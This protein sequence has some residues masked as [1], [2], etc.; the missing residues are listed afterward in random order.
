MREL[1]LKLVSDHEGRDATL[2]PEMLRDA[3]ERLA[4]RL[5]TASRNA[6]SDATRLGRLLDEE[7]T[8]I[9]RRIAAFILLLLVGAS[10]LLTLF[11]LRMTRTITAS[12]TTLRK[13]TE[14]VGAGNLGHRMGMATEDEIGELSSSFDRMT[15]R[16][17]E[18]T[19]SRDALLREMEE[20]RR[21]EQALR[22]KNEELTRLN[23]AMV[24]RELR[25]IELKR[26]VD[27]LRARAGLA[28]RYAPDAEGD[29]P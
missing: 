5:L 15:E 28:P 6:A 10:L 13:G 7:L 9:Q 14:V 21:A 27:E 4:G 22:G 8:G 25:M 12:L 16:L 3:E 2:K 17:R 26:E 18:L 19:V 11:L 20:R 29:G 24:G 1:F 23:R